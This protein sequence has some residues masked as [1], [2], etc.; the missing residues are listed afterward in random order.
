MVVSAVRSLANLWIN[1]P[2]ETD[3]AISGPW[4]KH[5]PRLSPPHTC[6][7]NPFCLE[8]QKPTSTPILEYYYA[9]PLL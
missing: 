3:E 6:S 2:N 7:P 4:G 1:C 9:P 5:L 8:P